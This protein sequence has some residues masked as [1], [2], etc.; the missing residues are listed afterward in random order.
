MLSI[1]I[2]LLLSNKICVKKSVPDA[3]DTLFFHVCFW[4]YAGWRNIFEREQLYL[5][6]LNGLCYTKATTNFTEIVKI[7]KIW[8][9]KLK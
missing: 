5:A 3:F 7:S 1:D 9:T 6:F 4:L 2:L 8:I